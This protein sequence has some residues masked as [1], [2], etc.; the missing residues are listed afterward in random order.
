MMVNLI[1]LIAIVGKFHSHIQGGVAT[2][3]EGSCGTADTWA[4]GLHV[5]INALSSI[6]LSASNYTMQVLCSPTR[7]EIDRAHAK[8]DWVDIG[9]FF[10]L[11]KDPP[12]RRHTAGVL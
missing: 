9:M 5:V 11:R 12:R 7:G 3:F 4:T 6:L 1:S 2:I 8:G 10:V